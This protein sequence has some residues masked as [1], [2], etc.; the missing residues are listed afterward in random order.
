MRKTYRFAVACVNANGEPDFY[1]VRVNCTRSQIQRGDAD[2]RIHEDAEANDYE[3]PMLVFGEDSPRTWKLFDTI[4]E[5]Q[6]KKTT[7]LKI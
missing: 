7:L 5:G 6:W 2:D 3:R 1:F 4:T